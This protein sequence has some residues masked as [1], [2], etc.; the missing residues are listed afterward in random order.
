MKH[1]DDPLQNLNKALERINK[2][3]ERGAQIICL[4]ELFLSPYFCQT[5]NKK[6]FKLAEPVPGPLTKVLQNVARD[7]G[8]VLVGSLYEKAGPHTYFNTAVVIDADGKYLGK[9][10]KLHIPN[11]PANYYGEAYYFKPGDLGV[12]VFKTKFGKIA[13]LVCWDQWFPEAAR[14]AALKGAQIIFYPTA[15]GWQL[16]ERPGINEA[17]YEGWQVMQR[18]HAIANNVF[19]A[20]VNRVGLEHKLKF[21]GTSFVADP[22]GRLLAKAPNHTEKDL[23]V[24]CDLSLIPQM[25]KDWP[26]LKARRLKKL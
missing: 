3:A 25:R 7:N 9:Y 21:W 5:R 17:E 12:K 13:P 16:T 8:V 4:S 6:Y 14:A 10:R 23:L 15:I 18:A 26:F 24:E 20:A 2:L 11:D 1:G 22:Y 19:I